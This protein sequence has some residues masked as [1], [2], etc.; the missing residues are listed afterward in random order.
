M[1]FPIDARGDSREVAARR[2][3]DLDLEERLC[4]GPPPV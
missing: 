2:L 4:P 3:T 1:A